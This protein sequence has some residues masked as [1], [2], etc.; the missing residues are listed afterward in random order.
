MGSGLRYIVDSR[1]DYYNNKRWGK[2]IKINHKEELYHATK[3]QVDYLISNTLKDIEGIILSNYQIISS[4]FRIYT[5][6]SQ[7]RRASTMTGMNSSSSGLM[8]R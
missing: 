7:I 6:N 5:R 1:I 4:S 8:S 2:I 3:R